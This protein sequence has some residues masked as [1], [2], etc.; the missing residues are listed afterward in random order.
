MLSNFEPRV[1]GQSL[2]HVRGYGHVGQFCALWCLRWLFFTTYVAE[3]DHTAFVKL[4]T[5]LS[6]LRALCSWLYH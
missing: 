3:G 2:S 4:I 5:D 6:D 1:F